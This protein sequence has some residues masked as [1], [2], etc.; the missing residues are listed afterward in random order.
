MKI[1]YDKL[2]IKRPGLN[3]QYAKPNLFDKALDEQDRIGWK[4][5]MK[6]IFSREWGKIQEIEYDKI[7]KRE[8]L[9][10]WYTGTWWTKH[11]IKNI[12]FWALNEWQKRNEHLHKEVEQRLIEKKRK[13][14][15]KDIVELYEKQENRPKGRMKR[16]FNMPL[17]DK[18]QQNPNRQRQWIESIRALNDKTT[19]QNSKN[20][21]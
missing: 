18:L 3:V 7:R 16:Y 9:E 1:F 17:I 6:G 10:V 4:L 11:L 13:E 5:T 12:I 15:H 19:T 2:P 20:R 8:K 14:N 21:P